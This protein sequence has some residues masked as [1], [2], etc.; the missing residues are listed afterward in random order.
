VPSSNASAIYAID[1]GGTTGVAFAIVD[2]SQPTV[3]RCIK[4]AWS[5]G[6]LWT[7][8]VEGS[9]AEQAWKISRWVTDFFFHYHIER[10]F[11]TAGR[12]YIAIEDFQL[13]QMSADLAPVRITAG[14]ETLLAGAFGMEDLFSDSPFYVKQQ[15]SHAKGFCTDD[16]L[17]RWGLLKKR[18]P[19]ERDALRHLVLRVNNLMTAE[20]R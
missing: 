8:N 10:S 14:I 20:G 4:R 9:H 12:T 7:E 3:A 11:I 18:S 15:P 2:I 5:K 13:R 6:L 19:H 16:M 17:R 1:P